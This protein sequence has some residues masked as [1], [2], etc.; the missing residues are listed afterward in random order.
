MK[1]STL[2]NSFLN[3][4]INPRHWCYQW[5]VDLCNSDE[6]F[7]K[8]LV[9]QQYDF[10]H[11]L[12][13]V[14]LFCEKENN[15]KQVLFHDIAPWIR[16]H[17]KKQILKELVTPYPFGIHNVIKRLSH[18]P[19]SKQTYRQLIDLL[20]K[21]KSGKYLQHA[22]NI[23]TNIIKCLSLLD[24]SWRDLKFL[25]HIKSS[26]DVETLL[27]IHRAS[28]KLGVTHPNFND[29][30]SLHKIDDFNAL[31]GWFERRLYS[32]EF[33]KPPWP[34]NNNIFPLTDGIQ[35]NH[36]S[37]QFRNCVMDYFPDILLGSCYFYISNYVPSIIKVNK[38]P[39]FDWHIN[40]ILGVENKIINTRILNKIR[41]E[42]SIPGIEKKTDI[43][44][45]QPILNRL[46]NSWI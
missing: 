38:D 8:H 36:T 4:L 32:I 1:P 33:P 37:K 23:S 11:F 18:K 24:P 21:S 41:D 31:Y 46:T 9:E 39:T 2:S 26:K 42:F 19:F 14:K 16:T 10:I 35:L 7:F 43:D 27:Y 34:G 30:Q 3:S 15:H 44:F 28:N 40:E 20:Y 13:I 5:V 25:R 6:L 29:I 22:L 45:D 12:C 17:S